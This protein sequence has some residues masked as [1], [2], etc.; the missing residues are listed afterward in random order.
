MNHLLEK[1]FK[2]RGIKD[3][4]TLDHQEQQT[5]DN[6]QKILSEGEITVDKVKQFCETQISLIEGKFKDLDNT[7]EKAQRLTISHSV[8]KAILD[9]MEKPQTERE[10]LEKYL[11]QLIES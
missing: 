6:W 4:M 3:T 5:Y 9:C 7:P 8:Y 10:N 2:K 11:H 1:L